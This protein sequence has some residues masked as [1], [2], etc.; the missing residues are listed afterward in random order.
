MTPD[1]LLKQLDTW[2]EGIPAKLL[3]AAASRREEVTPGLIAA[4]DEV[5]ANPKSFVE[6]PD[7]NLYYWATYLLTSFDEA[8]AFHSALRMFDLNRGEFAELVSDI[9]ADDGG[10]I[11]AHLCG[12]DA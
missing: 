11:L 1:Q 9:V 4:L 10:M 6:N 3:D 5:A 2:N 7:R 12:G 8:K